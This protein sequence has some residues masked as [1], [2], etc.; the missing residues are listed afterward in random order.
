M[1]STDLTRRL[2]RID[3]TLAWRDVSV[4]Y[5]LHQ[6]AEPFAIPS[7]VLLEDDNQDAPAPMQA[8]EVF[9]DYDQMRGPRFEY[10]PLAFGPVQE[11][12]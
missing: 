7:V 2:C 5:T 12:A 3:L 9:A 10:I 6:S 1:T 11:A 8:L 4:L